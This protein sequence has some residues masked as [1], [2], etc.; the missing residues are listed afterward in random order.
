MASRYHL[1]ESVKWRVGR[2]EAGQSITETAMSEYFKEHE[3][4]RALWNVTVSVVEVADGMGGNNDRW[5]YAST[6]VQEADVTGQIYRDEVLD[7]YV[8]LQG[9]IWTF[10]YV[11][12]NARPHRANL[13]DEFLEK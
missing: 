2:L 4:P 12:D 5:T 8:R 6:R 10:I 9:C 1:E 11:D 13:V 7:P 3:I